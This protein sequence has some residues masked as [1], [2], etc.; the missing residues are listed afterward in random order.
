MNA[1]ITPESV[2]LEPGQ[3]VECTISLTVSPQL[4][5]G[6]H[7]TTRIRFCPDGPELTLQTLCALPHPTI[8]HDAAGWRRVWN[9]IGKDE[10]FRAVYESWRQTAEQWQPEPAAEGADYCYFTDTETPVMCAA[11]C[12]ALT[13]EE[14]FAQKLVQFFRYFAQSYPRRLRGCHQSYVQEGHFF[15]H[16]AIPYDIVYHSPLLTAADH[17]AIQHCFRLYMAMLDKDIRN[18]HISNW[19]L[20]E[21]TGAVYCALAMQDWAAVE[22]FVFGPG[23]TVQ[24]L[25]CG[26]FSDGW[27]HEGSIGYNTWV[28]S[29]FLHTAHALRPFGVDMVYADFP[30]NAS[31]EVRSTFAARPVEAP[32]AMVNRKWGGT[33]RPSLHIKD[34]F[35]A[36][37]PFLDW[38]GVMFGV[39][40]SDEKTIDGV[41]F[42]ST[43]EL[44]YHYYRDPAY[45]PIIR[46]FA[47][48]DVV[49]GTPGLPP[50]D[51]TASSRCAVSDNIGLALLRSQTPGRPQREQI[52]AVLHYGS[53][54]GAHGHFDIGDLLSVM[55][56][57]RSLF[58]PEC[59]WWG[60]RHFMYK[61]HVQNS[62]TKNM[63]NVD[64]KMQL[65]A[66]SRRI[67][68]YSGQR[69]QAA[70]VEVCARWAYP[71]YG[72][73]DYDDSPGDFAKRL[74][75]N[76][77]WF[78]IDPSLCYAQISGETEPVFQRRLLA[79]T[80]DYL[81]LFDYAAGSEPHQYE[82]TFQFKGL[83]ALENVAPTKHTDQYT[84]DPASD[85]QMITDCRWY[86]GQG[87]VTARF[88]NRFGPGV[89]RGDPSCTESA[90]CG[91]RSY[92]N[93]PGELHMDV[94][95][96]WP[97]APTVVTGLM[98]T[99]IGWPADKDGYNIPLQWRVLTD[100]ETAAHG[101][102]DAWILG[103]GEADIP[104]NGVTT[105]TLCAVQ[106]DVANE[107]GQPVRTPPALFWGNAVLTLA[108]GTTRRLCELPYT[109]RNVLP[110]AGIGRDYEGGRVLVMGR[111]LPDALPASTIDHTAEGQLEFDLTGLDAVRLQLCIGADPYPGS[112]DQRRRFLAFRASAAPA[113]RFITVLEP[114]ESRRMVQKVTAE[115]PDAVTVTLTDGRVQTITVQ[116]MESGVPSMILSEHDF[117]EATSKS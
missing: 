74:R 88:L 69:L 29:M 5:P 97:P 9:N 112:E 71:P 23:G 17:A 105:L 104:L 60:Y 11:Y 109:A 3:Q 44:A 27:W 87:T 54:G 37:V 32:F 110:S 79:V 33:Q 57:G 43:Y 64:D 59:S 82:T 53:H 15:Q 12:Y 28:S 76:T 102:F 10:R 20:S 85:G 49:F 83:R 18:G 8:Y 103:R 94:Y 58:N 6:M 51:N 13:G 84:T 114:Y 62:L 41:H 35:D 100:G 46:S 16:L 2:T 91:D 93:E 55:R 30:L 98:A 1:A 38:R 21:V 26:A 113:A 89:V 42:G 40:D 52:Q 19:V 99:Y 86:E 78:P 22:R 66:D 117:R 47:E 80:D 67:L 25:C 56:C 96:A 4:C 63:L 36:V 14:Q 92:H 101:A 61:W 108:D 7:E 24:Q 95:A 65:P 72:G 90:L 81:V 106:G 48:P 116:N 50:A 73:M 31:L 70:G 68:F 115:G 75:M 34:L 107:K 111:E 77:A 39:N 45:L